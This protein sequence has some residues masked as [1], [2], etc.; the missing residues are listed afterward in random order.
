MLILVLTLL[1]SIKLLIADKDVIGGLY[2]KKTYPIKYVVNTLEGQPQQE[3]GV[4]EVEN[5]GTGFLMM[6]RSAIQTMF[7][8][9]PKY[10]FKNQLNLEPKFEPYMYTLFDT[11]LTEDGQYLSEDWTFCRRWRKLGGKIHAHN[12]VK[13]AH[14]GYHPSKDNKYT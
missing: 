8:A 5:I 7:D 13:L 1:M 11:S 9:Y 2:P 14:A 4:Q 3:T 10:K 6:K 12:D